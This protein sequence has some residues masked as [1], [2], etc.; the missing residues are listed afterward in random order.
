MLP[1]LTSL[2][3][4]GAAS[5][6]AFPGMGG[7]LRRVEAERR[8]S[9]STGIFGSTTSKWPAGGPYKKFPPYMYVA[10]VTGLNKVPDEA[11]PFIAPGPTDQRGPCP[12][13]NTYATLPH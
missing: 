8:Q 5:V 4:I 10:N 9:G 13:M 2:V 1:Q 6:A 12:G 7:T 3:V 11:H